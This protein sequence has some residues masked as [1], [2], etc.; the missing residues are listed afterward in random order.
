M[1]LLVTAKANLD[2]TIEKGGKEGEK[3]DAWTSLLMATKQG[4]QKAVDILAKGKANLEAKL[5]DGSTALALA[6]LLEKYDV[7]KS[8]L[9]NGADAE[10]PLEGMSLL[11][12]A[13][14]AGQSEVM[15]TL[16]GAKANVNFATP[17]GATA[18]HIATGEKNKDAISTLVELKAD[19][20][21]M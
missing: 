17:E 2:F 3:G 10:A 9:E 1:T 15:R 5:N 20:E 13:A 4:D 14:H 21:K 7:A 11:L 6:C 18:L 19:M 8:L 16:V 12:R